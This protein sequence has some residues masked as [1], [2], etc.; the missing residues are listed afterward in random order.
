MKKAQ[1][2][3]LATILATV[4]V[5]VGWGMRELKGRQPGAFTSVHAKAA[6]VKR[7]MFWSAAQYAAGL[8][9]SNLREKATADPETPFESVLKPA[10]DPL[11]E[12]NKHL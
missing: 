6:D 8:T 3:E 9:L 5:I 1:W 2:F 10:P 7:D 4:A 12:L 11:T